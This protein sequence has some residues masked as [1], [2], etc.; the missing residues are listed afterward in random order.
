MPR[1]TATPELMDDPD[2]DR[3]AL[4]RTYA[5]FAL[6][7]RI[8]A[9]WRSTY[10]RWLRPLMDAGTT[11]TVLDLGSGGGDIAGA[12]VRW[13]ASDGLAVHVTAADPDPR[14]C[15]FATA[16]PVP[17]GVTH[18]TAGSGDL[19][20][21]GDRFDLVISNHLLHH[22]GPA[23]LTGVL[24]ESSRLARR[25]VV[26]SDIARSRT[27]HELY[28]VGSLPFGNRS[29]VR[30]DGLLSVRRSYTPAEVRS[31]VP[32]GWSVSTPRLFRLLVVGDGRAPGSR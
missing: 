24:D 21:A 32:P 27:A 5:Q 22:L 25:R 29:F 11:T 2:C 4:D 31:L 26:H 16:R 12:L 13:A 17:A 3:A 28:R 8:V 10:R 9:G 18:V 1:D 6:V 30:Y 23:E 20:A 14:A 19:L 15:A 7:N